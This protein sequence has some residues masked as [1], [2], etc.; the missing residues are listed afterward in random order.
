MKPNNPHEEFLAML[1]AAMGR[2]VDKMMFTDPQIEIDGKPFVG[3]VNFRTGPER[4]G[5]FFGSTGL[6]IN[7]H[8]LEAAMWR[9]VGIDIDGGEDG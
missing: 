4:D 9:T 7:R 1:R 8:E 2:E 5:G 6:P 3:A